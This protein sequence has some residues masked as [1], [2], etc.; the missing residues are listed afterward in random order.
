MEINFYLNII[1]LL[2]LKL[3]ISLQLIVLPFKISPLNNNNSTINE[4]DQFYNSQIYS[5][6]SIG[7]PAQTVNFNFL[8]QEDRFY[9]GKGKC[10]PASISYFNSIKSESFSLSTKKLSPFTD[11]TQG[12]S[13]YEKFSFYSN[14]N[15][16]ENVTINN[17]NFYFGSTNIKNNN[18]NEYCGNIGLSPII[19]TTPSYW[20]DDDL[21]YETAYDLSD[22]VTSLKSNKFI[23]KHIWTYEYFD[24]K[25]D[26]IKNKNITNNYDGLV[27]FGQ[28]PHEY[29]PD[30]YDEASLMSI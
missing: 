6:I 27:I 7:T 11:I 17:Y 18:T 22:F 28:Y 2:F 19:T 10:Y 4:Y 21:D 12:F 30:K 20:H 23:D 26:F 14:L 3:K 25:N 16:N 15:C 24:K 8:L 29:C 13:A 5:E 9:I 1:A